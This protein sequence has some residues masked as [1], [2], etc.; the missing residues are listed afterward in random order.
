MRA[1]H[2][3]G[4]AVDRVG[5]ASIGAPIG[6]GV[7]LGLPPA[8]LLEAVTRQFHNLLDYTVPVVSVLRGARISKSIAESLGGMDIDDLWLGYFCVST[9]L[10]ASRLEVHNRGELA[11]AVRASV[12]IPGVLPPVPYRGDLLVDGGV[13]A[14]LPV[15]PMRAHPGIGSVIAVNVASEA[16]PRRGL[17]T[18]CRS[19][20]GRRS[21]L[22]SGGSGPRTRA[23]P[24]C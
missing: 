5:G 2:E 12:A 13:L 11:L 7:A 9:N 20:V 24:E 17:T 15:E 4:V 1:L 19:P 8:E 21:G 23:W 18:A 16:G 10:A 22:V 6:A 14:N 3:L